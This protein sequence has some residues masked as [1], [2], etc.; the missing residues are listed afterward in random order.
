MEKIHALFSSRKA[1]L[2]GISIGAI[3]LAALIFHAGVVYGSHRSRFGRDD[4]TR[5]FRPPFFPGNFEL[6]HGFL[7]NNHGAIGTITTISL[8]TFTMQ[9]REGTSQTI[10]MG[11]TTALRSNK[12]L[13]PGD[14]VIVL[15]EPDSQGRIDAMLIRVLSATSTRP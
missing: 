1:R 11:S 13:A 4:V 10:L 6:P 12:T 15:G 3:L 7:Q 8:P 5:G 2:I 14:E 9:T